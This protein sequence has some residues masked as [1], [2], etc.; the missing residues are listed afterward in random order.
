MAH[1]YHR[2]LLSVKFSCV[3]A[4]TKSG[5]PAHQ[6]G[7]CPHACDDAPG[8][9][10]EFLNA[11][12]Q[13]PLDK[14]AHDMV[15]NRKGLCKRS[16]TDDGYCICKRSHGLARSGRKEHKIEP[17][18]DRQQSQPGSIVSHS[19]RSLCILRG[20]CIPLL[21]ALRYLSKRGCTGYL[22]SSYCRTV[23]LLYACL[24]Q[25]TTGFSRER[26]RWLLLARRRATL[27]VDI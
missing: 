24:T 4:L 6:P 1:A 21:A 17:A 12:W 11:E 27:H 3:Q 10:L 2:P 18:Q 23:V 5:W 14:E 9:T 25:E 7:H 26:Q 20:L 19:A 8:A 13:E 16:H 15:F 22:L